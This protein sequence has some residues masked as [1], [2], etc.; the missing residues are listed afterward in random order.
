[1]SMPT[2]ELRHPL[3]GSLPLLPGSEALARLGS[4]SKF[5]AVNSGIQDADDACLPFRL[6]SIPRATGHE[7]GTSALTVV[8]QP[9]SQVEIAGEEAIRSQASFHRS[10]AW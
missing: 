2:E 10:M 4:C 8:T 1:M 9:S 3:P 6:C 5:C 7:S